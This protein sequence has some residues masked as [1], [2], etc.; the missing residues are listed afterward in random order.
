[1]RV[2]GDVRHAHEALQDAGTLK[3][4]VLL[5][6][7]DP[8]GIPLIAFVTQLRDCYPGSKILV[9]GEQVTP[10]ALL[11]LGTGIAGYLLW[12]NLTAATLLHCLATVV[13]TDLTVSSRAVAPQ[14]LATLP[15][16]HR[17]PPSGIVLCGHE[18][19]V[20]RRL[21]EGM[22]QEEISEVEHLSL[23]TVKRTIAALEAKVEAPSLFMLGMK[24]ER[25]GLGS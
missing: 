4:D 3:P 9:L 19:A 18:R 2:V 25:L 24:V 22:Q 6:T 17:P 20:L 14:V 5:I 23:R 16:P 1:M 15:H 8:V 10:D 11:L 13:E 7:A 12:P 21:S